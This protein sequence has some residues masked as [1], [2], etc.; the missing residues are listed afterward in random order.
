MT[1]A[2]LDVFNY[3]ERAERLVDA[4]ALS[5][6]KQT[7]AGL[8][9]VVQLQSATLHFGLH[10][11]FLLGCHD[12]L[13]LSGAVLPPPLDHAQREVEIAQETQ[14]A[15]PDGPRPLTRRLAKLLVVV[16]LHAIVAAGF[17]LRPNLQFGFRRLLHGS[18][19]RE[20]AR[21]GSGSGR[22]CRHRRL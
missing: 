19:F 10:R 3:A 1:D 17:H 8:L 4:S 12:S 13:S 5:C 2:S 18:P 20:C 11:D 9:V 22:S 15:E 7:L 14:K 21:C 16:E 6:L